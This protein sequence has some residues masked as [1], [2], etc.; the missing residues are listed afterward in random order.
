MGL[1]TCLYETLTVSNM[2]AHEWAIRSLHDLGADGCCRSLNVLLFLQRYNRK[3][4]SKCRYQRSSFQNLPVELIV[5][6]LAKIK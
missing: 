3:G 6:G 2:L 4:L 5:L 1:T